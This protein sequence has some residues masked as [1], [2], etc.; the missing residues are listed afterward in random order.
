MKTR[1]FHLSLQNESHLVKPEVLLVTPRKKRISGVTQE[2]CKQQK[3]IKARGA[4]NNLTLEIRR[5]LLIV[6]AP[7]AKN[8]PPT[9]VVS[10]K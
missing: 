1:L 4:L 5:K 2:L 7:K 3:K 10:D 6:K 8:S 9:R